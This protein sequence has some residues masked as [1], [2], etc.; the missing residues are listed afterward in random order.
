MNG[1]RREVQEV[2]CGLE[3]AS[4]PKLYFCPV[5]LPIKLPSPPPPP[6]I[7][8]VQ[9]SPL[10]S[11]PM[12]M[13]PQ[14]PTSTICHQVNSCR[15]HIKTFQLRYLTNFPI[16]PFH[17]HAPSG[18]YF[19]AVIPHVSSFDVTSDGHPSCASLRA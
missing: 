3:Q 19:D 18:S 7:L 11:P 5:L 12:S 16:L 10:R 2:R 1:G 13:V 9:N 8:Q 15:R 14:V 17:F 4:Y 6:K